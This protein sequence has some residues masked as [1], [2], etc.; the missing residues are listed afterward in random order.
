MGVANEMVLDNDSVQ[1]I[2][3]PDEI[4]ARISDL[5]SEWDIDKAL[6]VTGAA[7]G[8]AGVGL[9]LTI[10][11]KFLALPALVLGFMVQQGI[12]G[13]SPA[14]PLLRRAGFRTRQEIWAECDELEEHLRTGDLQLHDEREM[15]LQRVLPG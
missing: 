11:R 6:H 2:G 13:W 9:G 4:R 7:V 14:R 15:D 10:S 5:E 3:R 8:L 12:Q 1:T